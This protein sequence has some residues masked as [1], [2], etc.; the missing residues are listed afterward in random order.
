MYVRCWICLPFVLAASGAALGQQAPTY[1]KDVRPFFAKY[2]LECHNS[3]AQKAGLDLETFKSLQEGSDRG[4]VLIPGKPDESLLVVLAEGKKDPKMPPKKAQRHPGPTEVAVLRK[5]VAAGAADDGAGQKTVIIPDIKPRIPVKPAVA[6]LAYRPDSKLL[7]AG[8]YNE[9]ILV[10]PGPGELVGKLAGQRGAVTT[11]AWS[12]EGSRLAVASGTTGVAGEMRVY[13]VTTA[14]PPGPKLEH[15]LAG[16]KD[17]I[18]DASFAPDGRTLA[19]CGYDRLIILWDVATG[20]QIRTLK[21]HSD[22]VYSV[23]FSPNG[24]WLASGAAD[25]AVKVWDAAT[26]KLIY[27]LS[28]PTDWVYTVA[29]SPDGMHLAAGG[30]DKS[31]RVWEILPSGVKVVHSVFAHEGSVLRLVYDAN[32]ASLYSLGEDRTVKAWNTGSMKERK[33]YDRQPEATLALAIRPDRKQFSLGRYDGTASLVEE[34]TGKVQAQPLPVK[35]RPPQ[36]NKLSPEAV[37]R[38]RPVTVVFEG[39][40]L[41]GA[42]EVTVQHAGAVAKL[43]P[44]TKLPTTL[45]AEVTFPAGTPPGVYKVGLKNAVGSSA[46]NTLIVDPFP[47]IGEKEPN[48][49]PGT[50]QKIA[51]PATVVGAI[52]RA[53]DVDYYRFEATAGQQVGVQVLTAVLGSKLDAY[54]MLTDATGQML[55]ESMDGSLGYIFTQPGTYAVG[56]RDREFR[57]NATMFYRLHIGDL[58]VVTAVYPLGMQRGTEADIAVE[59]VNLGTTK[60]ILM[61][62]PE[63]T[64]PGTRLPLPAGSRNVV[65][66]EFPEV[67]A[68]GDAGAVLPVPATA[69]GRITEPGRTD[70]WQFHARKG[71]RLILE[72]EARR[73]G[74]PL[75]SMIEILD[76]KGQPV[77]RAVLRCLAKTYVTFRDHDSAGP[78]IRL[79][80]WNDLAINDMLYVGTELMRIFELPRNPDDDCQFYSRTGQ[81][82]GFLDTTPTHHALGT[83]MYKVSVHPPGT[84]FAPNG[85]PVFTLYY[86]N[87]DGGPGLSRDS[88]LYFDPPA[89]G[90]YQVRIADS[91]GQGG[92]NYVYRLTVRPPRPSFTV[93]FNPTSPAVWKG[94]AIPITA[95]A[96]RLD[97]Y[98]GPIALRL[99]NLPPG[100]SAPATTIPAGEN[101]TAF[102]LYA[103]ASAVNPGKAPPLKLVAR[104]T[105]DG[106]EVIKAATGGLPT[107]QEPGDIMTT[108]ELPEVTVRP[109]QQVTVTAHVE[110]RNGF[111]GRIPLDVRGLPRGVRVLD[112]GLNGILVTERETTRTFVIYCEPWVQAQEHPFVVLAR[113]ESK[114]REHAAKSVLLKIVGDAR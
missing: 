88:R 13:A 35:P 44:D 68:A 82:I 33:V 87:D 112:V 55:G 71:Q 61:K 34:A 59:G 85:F 101:S 81:R 23:A 96:E 109:G 51:L 52:A 105:I 24:K 48:D 72:V 74:S 73:L 77:P 62:A 53:G 6:A 5:W 75:D 40:H 39:Q 17:V 86:R 107:V 46:L 63:A 11:L 95:T 110:R 103:D 69:N 102:S 21:E 113:Q 37:Q 108:T 19:T 9:V 3:T 29:W 83:P 98:E 7:A 41:D 56:I 1:A 106:R 60:S 93:S 43:V 30:V 18:L 16:H 22:S 14:N 26:G 70:T 97:G 10:D 92:R 66:G 49:S 42:A 65:V 50:G 99:E 27:T 79:E 94:G 15:V 76:S 67:V 45:V 2:C 104:A 32:G 38:G 114:N 80:T 31:I 84:T 20:A 57:G 36:L 54:L 91:R 47:A 64:A 100:F 89:D 90:P 58:P 111:T 25:R 12:R 8:G 78:G 4:P 28:E